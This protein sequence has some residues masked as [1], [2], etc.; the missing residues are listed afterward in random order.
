MHVLAR[1]F[2]FYKMG[3]KEMNYIDLKW[4][5]VNENLKYT[6]VL[7]NYACYIH[8]ISKFQCEVGLN[9]IN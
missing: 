1:D 8:N 6:Y 5:Q 3:W 2:Q 9:T 7:S 4:F